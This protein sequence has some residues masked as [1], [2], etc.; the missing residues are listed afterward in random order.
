MKVARRLMLMAAVGLVCLWAQRGGAPAGGTSG[1]TTTTGT[2]T[3]TGSGSGTSPTAPANP[4][5][6]N[7][8]PT[9]PAPVAPPPKPI[10]LAG[11]VIVDDGSPLPANVNIK[12]VCGGTRQRTVAHTSSAG[13]FGFQWGN[14]GGVFEDASESGH[15]PG[16][17][18]GSGSG[19]S[20]GGNASGSAGGSGGRTTDPLAD[21]DLQA[22]SPG[23]TSSK[24]SLYQH[25]SFDNFDVGAIV[26]HRITGDEGRV[27]SLLALKAPKDAKKNFDKGTDQ[28]R[29]NKLTDAAASFQKSVTTYPQYADAWLSLGRVQLQLGTKDAAR[30]SF[31]KAMDLDDKLVGPW[32]E[33]GYMASDQSKWEDAARYLDK[34]V[35]LDPMSSPMAW[36]FS[37]MANYNLGR[38]EEAERSVRAELKLDKNAHAEYLLGMVLI[39]RKDLKGGAD[40]LRTYLASSP[41]PEEAATAR[42]QLSQVE[43]QLGQ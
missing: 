35:R 15:G 26:L 21:C 3:G 37:A 34:A 36:Y 20:G 13:D 42:K 5:I 27:V 18:S 19:I 14:T 24:V 10:Y 11:T 38:F 39:A 23:Y 16:N 17:L 8:A 41:K 2:G 25:A 43:S 29:S 1:G 30:E 9:P 31:Q 7:P 12:S 22:E 40:A 32:Q 33:L 6:M 28:L 4:P